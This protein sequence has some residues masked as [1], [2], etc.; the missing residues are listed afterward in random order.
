[1]LNDPVSITYNGS[2]VALVKIFSSPEESVFQSSD[3]QFRLVI[4]KTM[5]SDGSFETV[6]RLEKITVDG[7]WTDGNPSTHQIAEIV[8]VAKSPLADETARSLLRTAAATFLSTY[9]SKLAGGE[10]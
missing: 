9:G 6:A 5:S 1:M 2:G 7:S 3:G 4:S 10:Y 8:G